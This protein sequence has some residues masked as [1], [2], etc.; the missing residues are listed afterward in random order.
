MVTVYH[1]DGDRVLVT[2]Y[3]SGN[4]QPRMRAAPSSSP[5]KQIAFSFVDVTNLANSTTGH[6]HKLE[7]VFD[8]ND[9]LTQRW[10][11]QENGRDQTEVFHY[12][13]KKS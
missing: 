12:T 4:N 9:H 13:R 1:P 7:V 5:V 11:W 2:H 8:D 10:T 3:C 6:M